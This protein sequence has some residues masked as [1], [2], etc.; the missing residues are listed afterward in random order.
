MFNPRC[1][2]N[3]YLPIPAHNNSQTQ[4][5]LHPNDQT[6]ST[7]SCITKTAATAH[8]ESAAL[9]YT[10][11]FLHDERAPCHTVPQQIYIYKAP[12]RWKLVSYPPPAC[13]PGYRSSLAIWPLL[14]IFM[15]GFPLRMSS[16]TTVPCANYSL[17]HGLWHWWTRW[18]I[19]SQIG[20]PSFPWWSRLLT[21]QIL[22]SVLFIIAMFLAIWPPMWIAHCSWKKRLWEAKRRL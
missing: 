5:H 13:S 21:H 6:L 14:M 3:Q 10:M 7:T 2:S 8:T 19:V 20:G 4:G 11:C 18:C 16:L 17:I 12:I 15:E 9:K 1:N 22:P